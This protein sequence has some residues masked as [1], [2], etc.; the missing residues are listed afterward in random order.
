MVSRKLSLI[1]RSGNVARVILNNPEKR[2][3]L[4]PEVIADLI[5]AFEELRDDDAI[6]VVVTTGAGDVSWSAGQAGEA[7]VARSEARKKGEKIKNRMQELNELV[8]NYPKVTIAA[9]NGY[10]LGAAITFLICHDLAMASE[11]RAVFG[12]PEVIRGFPP[13]SILCSIFRAV[14]TKWAFDMMLTGDNW[15]ARTAQKAGLIT[16][17]VP[18]SKLQELS[19]EWAK[20]IARWDRITLEYCKKAAHA[21]LDE[22]TWSKSMA[23]VGY[24]TDEHN[25]VNPRT[26]DG[27]RDFL[28]KKGLKASNAIKWV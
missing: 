17:I 3:N 28:A 22:A 7:L 21:G 9:V 16:R 5:A 13:R 27:M 19:L 11:E 2:N 10:C 18:H 12:L 14:P 8:R 23:I 6:A 25:L 24:I 26:H 15:D 20:E 1:E 4:S